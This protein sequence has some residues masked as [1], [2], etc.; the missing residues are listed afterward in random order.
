M[1]KNIKT[2]TRKIRVDIYIDYITCKIVLLNSPFVCTLSAIVVKSSVLFLK[3][4]NIDLSDPQISQLMRQLDKDGNGEI[5]F[6]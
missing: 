2:K 6:R 4:C 1:E 5:D 3:R